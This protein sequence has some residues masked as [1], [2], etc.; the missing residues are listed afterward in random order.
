VK[1]EL[2]AGLP[3]PQETGRTANAGQ[4]RKRDLMQ[5]PIF[6]KA[7][8]VLGAQ[9]FGAD[10]DFSPIPPLPQKAAPVSDDDDDSPAPVTDP[11]ES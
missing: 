2:K 3:A 5:L 1:F 9:I 10:D 8:E 4:V 11:E 7:A 6:K